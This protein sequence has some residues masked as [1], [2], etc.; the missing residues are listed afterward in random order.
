[1]N[2]YA[3]FLITTLAAPAAGA[4]Q[5]DARCLAAILWAE[6]QGEPLEGVI[7]VGQAAVTRAQRQH[8]SV[9]HITG[10]ARA[11]PPTS[12]AGALRLL[13]DAILRR[14][15]PAVAG[16]ADSWNTGKKPRQ[17]GDIR[18]VIGG[19]VLYAQR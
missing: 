19:H 10:V 12:M 18:R 1:M 3:L 13:A 15:L 6:A 14:R 4:A 16:N 11:A 5:T 9:C 8:T 2:R 17:P 7:A